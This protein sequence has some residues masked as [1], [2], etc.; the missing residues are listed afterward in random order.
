MTREGTS[1]VSHQEGKTACNQHA[2]LAERAC[3]D[4][5]LHKPGV[6][7]RGLCRACHSR[8]ARRGTLADFPSLLRSRAEVIEEYVHLKRD[9]FS[10]AQIAE[11]LEMSKDALEMHLRRAARAGDPRSDA[12]IGTH[13]TAIMPGHT[14]SARQQ[15]GDWRC[16][17][18][19]WLAS[20]RDRARLRL[21]VHHKE[22]LSGSA[23]N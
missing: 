17:C 1:S 16:S 21:D 19:E 11:R 3:L 22:V 18:G 6:Y 23:T 8:S 10:R 13:G 7:A 4:C 9:G 5:G 14:L 12:R 15:S 2:E 20:A